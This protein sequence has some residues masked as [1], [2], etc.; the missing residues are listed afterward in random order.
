M[1]SSSCMVVCPHPMA[2][3]LLL[4]LLDD[5]DSKEPPSDDRTSCATRSSTMCRRDECGACGEEGPLHGRRC[6]AAAAAAAEPS[7]ERHAK[8][9]EEHRWWQATMRCAKRV[10]SSDVKADEGRC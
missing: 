6:D 7:P 3:A 9:D 4:L 5:A 1:A 8:D 2:S 10:V